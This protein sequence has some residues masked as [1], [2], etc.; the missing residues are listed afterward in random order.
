MNQGK[1][2][3][4]LTLSGLIIGPLLGS[5]II[6]LPGIIYET[7][8]SYAILAWLIMSVIGIWFAYL[9]GELIIMFP[10]EEGLGNAMEKA[11]GKQVKNLS[12]VFLFIA[13][14]M[15]PVAV[16]MT[17]AEYL[18]S[19]ILFHHIKVEIIAMIL[20]VCNGV[21]LLFR[22]NFLG[23]LS[24]VISSI[25]VLILISGSLYSL[26]FNH[27]SE[28]SYSSFDVP[29]FG[30]SLL[31]LFW[32]IVGW[33]I[34]GNYSA[35]VKNMKATIRKAI[36]ISAFIITIVNLVLSAAVQWT[37]YDSSQFTMQLTGVLHPLFGGFSIGI[38][39][40][41]ATGLCVTTHLMVVGG[42]ARQIAS[43]TKSVDRLNIFT[44]KCKNGAP[45]SAINLLVMIHLVFAMLLLLNMVTVESLVGYANAF[46]IS[47]ALIGILSAVKL[48]TSPLK[49]FFAIVLSL[50]FFLLLLRSSIIALLIIVVLVLLFVGRKGGRRKSH[51]R[52]V[53]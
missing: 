50:L 45:I 10:G 17:A 26:I 33:E 24:L 12:S 9:C 5:G 21:I 11:F 30:H 31:L 14:L 49:K 52:K 18:H 42:V 48:F 3:G 32:T 29:S 36:F 51:I 7:S 6:L 19:W 28:V 40:I 44:K 15:G 13:A 23:K 4:H 16:M 25:A 27:L 39:T 43:L 34:V 1:K 46:F 41:V 38:L 35:E 37:D 22:L 2:I 53:G 47:N 8:G 20:L